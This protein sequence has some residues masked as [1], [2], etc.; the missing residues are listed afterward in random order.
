MNL[1]IE[2]IKEQS[3]KANYQ[4]RTLLSKFSQKN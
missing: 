2:R 1:N 3:Y 4:G